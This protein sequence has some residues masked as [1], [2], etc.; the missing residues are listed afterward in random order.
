VKL[1]S[2][3]R[4]GLHDVADPLKPADRPVGG[5]GGVGAVEVAGAQ[6]MPLGAVAQHVPGGGEHRRGHDHDGFPDAP[7]RRQAV[8]PR[9][10]IAQMLRVA[11]VVDAPDAAASFDARFV[12]RGSRQARWSN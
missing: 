5:L 4:R 2:T 10:R 1:S 6:V 7:V 12:R 8:E 3:S 9:F 11:V